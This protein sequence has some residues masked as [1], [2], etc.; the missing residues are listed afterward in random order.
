MTYRPTAVER[1]FILAA[2]GH[3][4]GVSEIRAALRAEGY[5]EEGQLHGGSIQKQLMKLI[6]KAKAEKSAKR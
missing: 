6:A 1:A 4:S 2:S 3:V 5:P